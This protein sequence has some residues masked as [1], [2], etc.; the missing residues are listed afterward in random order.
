MNRL[1]LLLFLGLGL[2]GCNKDK[3]IISVDRLKQC[4]E[5]NV[6]YVAH[7]EPYKLA[8]ASRKSSIMRL[9]RGGAYYKLDLGKIEVS[10]RKVE[11]G[12]SIVVKLPKLKIEPQPDPV[13][14][15]EFDPKTKPLVNDTGLNR[16]REM[17]DEMDREKIATA[18]NQPE[19]IEMAKEQSEEIVRKMLPELTV[20][21]EWAE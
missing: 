7:A 13:R 4:Q 6:L 11:S 3:H 21:I 10:E 9:V 15:V 16:I 8:T 17:Y 18:A 14:S 20:E 1:L 5:I 12:E 19:Y 2:F